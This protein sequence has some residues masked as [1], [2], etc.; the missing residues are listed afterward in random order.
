VQTTPGAIGVNTVFEQMVDIKGAAT[1]VTWK[2]K[3]L[4][5][6]QEL[7]LKGKMKVDMHAWYWPAKVKGAQRTATAGRSGPQQGAHARA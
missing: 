1:P 5:P 7:I 4:A 6:P 3:T 2:V